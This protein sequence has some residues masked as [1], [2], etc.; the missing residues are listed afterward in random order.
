[1]NFDTLASTA[2]SMW[3]AAQA[4]DTNPIT[5]CVLGPPGVGKSACGKAISD[6]MTAQ[7]QGK[8]PSAPPARFMAL[9]LS[10]MLP[11]DLM[12][13]PFRSGD[14][15]KYCPQSWLAPFCEEGAYGVLVL[16]DLPAA[17]GQVQV[18]CRQVSLDRRI[19]EM[20]LAPGVLVIVTG[21]RR[22]DKAGASTLPS[23]FRNSVCIL[24]YA[25]SFE[26]WEQWYATSGG[27]SD[28]PAFLH[29]RSTYF[30]RVPKDADAKGSFA[31]PR[32]WAMLGRVI[33]SIPDEQ[34]AEFASGLV[35]E[36]VAVEFAAFRMLRKTLVTPAK[37]MADPR[38]SLPDPKG[39]L[40]SPDKVIAL[41]TGLG[42]HAAKTAKGRGAEKVLVQFLAALGWA[43]SH[44]REYTASAINTFVASGG[45]MGALLS[46]SQKGRDNPDIR[47]L[48]AALRKAL[49]KKGN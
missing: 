24:N 16:D 12:G 15:T 39:T 48:M 6:M 29:F 13:L 4:A 26:G 10:S 18:A 32:T 36:G 37:L 19:H 11:E 7:V 42:E 23:H 27:N 3:S 25:P 1:M 47:D 30:S 41:A 5:L 34:Q 14:I 40:D 21:N 45:K 28:I 46:A 20:N 33:D 8:N 31:T 35:G 2:M 44:N 22:E 17:S 38:G 43:T 49:L 9:D